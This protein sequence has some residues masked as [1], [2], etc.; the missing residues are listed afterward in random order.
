MQVLPLPSSILCVA[1]FLL[2]TA[3]SLG[4]RVETFPAQ[5]LPTACLIQLRLQTSSA[6]LILYRKRCINRNEYLFVGLL[7]QY[8]PR[9]NNLYSLAKLN[10]VYGF[11]LS[12]LFLLYNERCLPSLSET[13]KYLL[14]VVLDTSFFHALYKNKCIVMPKTALR[15]YSSNASELPVK[16]LFAVT[17]LCKLSHDSCQPLQ[18]SAAPHYMQNNVFGWAVL[19]LFTSNLTQETSSLDHYKFLHCGGVQWAVHDA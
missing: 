14:Y 10:K 12:P 13:N 19:N 5:A 4:W 9:E 15:N 18:A 8:D 2:Y 7:M 3:F 16:L 1:H 11:P 17:D 6:V